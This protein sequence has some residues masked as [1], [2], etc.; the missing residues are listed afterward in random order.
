MSS[1]KK[2]NS[3]QAKEIENF[4]AGWTG[5]SQG[6]RLDRRENRD[7]A[8][9]SREKIPK[10]L[11]PDPS[12]K[13]LLV[14]TQEMQH[15]ED[16]VFAMQ[17]LGTVASKAE[18]D[19]ITE[20]IYHS[21]YDRFP[22]RVVD[23]NAW[24]VFP[25]PLNADEGDVKYHQVLLRQIMERDMDELN[26]QEEEMDARMKKVRE[27]K[28]KAKAAS[29]KFKKENME[30]LA[31]GEEVKDASELQIDRGE[32]PEVKDVKKDSKPLP[33]PKKDEDDE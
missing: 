17:F 32:V 27:L 3:Q 26:R 7:P 19:E 8:T 24:R 6:F 23:L 13:F 28:E 10:K 15:P 33:P 5:M 14:R 30:R 31:R 21:G 18:A 25:P 20:E 29:E 22:I 16:P 11:L 4:Y 9:V 1:S 2:S 12:H